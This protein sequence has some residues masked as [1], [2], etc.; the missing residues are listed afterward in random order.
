MKFIFILLSY[1]FF[2]LFQN[3]SALADPAIEGPDR[4]SLTILHLN[5]VHGHYSGFNVENGFCL[6]AICPGGWGGSVRLNRIIKA[7]RALQPNLLLLNAGDDFSG[8]I[9]WKFF[10]EKP[11]LLVLNSL[12]YDAFTLGNHE[13]DGG[14]DLFVYFVKELKTP[15]VSANFNLTAP[16]K[17]L[18][19]KPY[20]IIQRSGRKIG[21]IGLTS[22]RLPE[23]FGASFSEEM[24]ALKRA[25][26]SLTQEGA[27]III[28]L[29]HL[30][31]KTD[32]ELA[33]KVEGL[34][35]VV[36]GDSH[37]YLGTGRTDDV[38]PYPIIV[39]SPSGRQVLVVTSGFGGR[40]LGRLIV[41]FDQQGQALGWYGESVAITD[42]NVVK[43][44]APEADEALVKGLEKFSKP[45]E[46]QLG[47]VLGQIKINGQPGPFT[48]QIN[49]RQGECLSANLAT[50][51]MRSALPSNLPR[52]AIINSGAI[53]G[54]IPYNGEITK[55]DLLTILPFDNKLAQATITG[56]TLLKILAN[57][58]SKLGSSKGAR[59]LQ[60]SGLKYIVAMKDEDYFVTSVKILSAEKWLDL[61]LKAYYDLTTVDYLSQG[62]D[63]YTVLKDLNWRY[64]ETSLTEAVEH[65]LSLGPAMVSMGDRVNYPLSKEK[66]L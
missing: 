19:L 41:D 43:L 45:L 52:L 10:K 33:S 22:A 59:L 27:N 6:K 46:A 62:G 16:V 11:A 9:F 5:D 24:E 49:C 3:Q 35:L 12:G 57:S 32:L 28:A 40:Y 20:V 18:N 29:T 2:L 15:V 60:V 63:G 64:S 7:Y 31:L 37:S 26:Q 65:Y 13:F 38:G 53:R 1:S 48:N 51:A 8:S 58:V 55:A 54:D 44:A 23:G 39:S 34:D 25:V 36:G 30:G 61:D 4:F 56:E 50:D 42:E 47:R 21:I 14:F 66:G 17:D